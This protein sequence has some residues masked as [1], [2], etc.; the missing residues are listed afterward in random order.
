VW[1][2]IRY[3]VRGLLRA[4]VFT[5]VASIS[6]ALAIGANATIFSL[7]DGIWF[8][9]PGVNDPGSVVR[10]FS[11]T[12]DTQTGAFSFP[13]YR[14]LR[15]H[16]KSL[17]SV[18]AVGR[19][20][21][22]LK[23]ADGSSEL[24]LVN[25]VSTN[26][27]QALGVKAGVGRL[28]A[29]GEESALDEHPAV[30][31]GYAFWQRHFGGDPSIVGRTLTLM[32]GDKPMP[33][34]VCGVLPQTFRDL[35][36][37]SDRDLWLP[38][39]TFMQ[40]SDRSEFEQR[41][42]RWF[43][44]LGR[45]GPAASVPVAQAEMEVLARAMEASFPATN[46]GRRA[47]VV[48][49]WKYRLES[50]GVNALALAGV[51]L[52]VVLI[53]CVNVANLLIARAATRAREIAV[54]LA[55]GASRA[56]LVRQLMTESLLLG[57]LG[58]ALG[59]VVSVWLVGLVPLLLVAPPG[60]HMPLVFEVDLRVLVFTLGV[61][62]VTTVLFGLAPSWL[63]SRAD[64]TPVFKADSGLAPAGSRHGTFRGALVAGQ[65]AVSLVLLCAAAVLTR[66][67]LQTRSAD[68]G[69]ERK[70]ILT[71]W[72]PF[73][74][75]APEELDAAAA[76]LEALPGVT[77]VAMAFRAPLSL[78]GGGLDQPVTFPDRVAGRGGAPE[79]KYNEVN[80]SYFRTLGIRLLNGRVFTRED[81]SP[82]A[83]VVVVSDRFAHQYFPSR[84]AVGQLVHL[85]G[86]AGSDY[87]IVGVVNDVVIGDVTEPREPYFY[88]PYSR[89]PHGEFTFLIAATRDAASLVGPA[90]RVLRNTNP[91]L[92]PRIFATMGQ[93]VELSAQQSRLTA[94]L[95]GVLGF[96]G[97]LLTTVGVYGVVAYN[98]TRR[99]RELAMRVALGARRGQVVRQVVAEGAR[100]T[101]VGLGIGVPL[102]MLG[103]RSM[104]AFLFDTQP[105]DAVSFVLAGVVLAVAVGLASLIPALRIARIDPARA[106]R[107]G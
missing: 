43:Q 64:L 1:H 72:V 89:Q 96:I 98:T 104:A 55:I 32:R 52:L 101:S 105:W 7:I 76:R 2:D 13:E 24:L 26:F 70:P 67:F 99:T 93:L 37:A 91:R 81:E 35:D 3:A 45:L 78:S 90:R 44:V 41:G 84:T 94:T 9:P 56:R 102:A 20:G 87:R 77:G 107:E 71:A 80:A 74:D 30:V 66:S 73:G 54:R 15:D 59:L 36:A 65:V 27:F 95:V 61:T 11:T 86:A 33:V 8:R 40:L 31:L 79:I 38:P 10:V 25:V 75:F 58:A 106:L 100:V 53:T 21:A 82:G 88:V 4:P 12:P 29:P 85:G 51:V 16:A 6:L 5:V 23:S 17:S 92:D 69:F 39:Q 49:D 97:L 57:A 50:G 18:V 63:A 68:L 46:A 103:T 14:E 47:R 22:L 42:Y 48:A 34:W 62:L 60:F 83:R 19:R 28:F